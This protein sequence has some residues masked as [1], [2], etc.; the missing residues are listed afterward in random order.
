MLLSDDSFKCYYTWKVLCQCD[1][2]YLDVFKDLSSFSIVR[3]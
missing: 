1:N 2:M 3:N